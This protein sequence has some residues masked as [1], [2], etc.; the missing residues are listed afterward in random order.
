MEKL[1]TDTNGK[2]TIII[3]REELSIWFNNSVLESIRNYTVKKQKT[4]FVSYFIKGD[5]G[6]N[7]CFFQY[8]LYLLSEKQIKLLDDIAKG[9]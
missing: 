2:L 7:F 9:D 3:T 5:Y 8:D 4:P 1:I 6:S